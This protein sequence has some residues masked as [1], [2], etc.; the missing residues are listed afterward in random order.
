MAWGVQSFDGNEIDIGFDNTCLP[1]NKLELLRTCD[2]T[3]QV[4]RETDTGNRCQETHKDMQTHRRTGN[5]VKTHRHRQ[6][7]RRKEKTEQK[8]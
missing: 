3:G 4:E 7:D 1:F 5:I 6:E 2:D 8:E